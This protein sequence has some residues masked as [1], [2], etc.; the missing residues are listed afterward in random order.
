[1][2][3]QVEMDQG[4]AHVTINRPPVN[5]IS[6]DFIAE[7]RDL[8]ERLSKDDAIRAV[9]FRS[10]IPGRF[11]AGADLSD[12]LTDTQDDEPLADRLRRANK[13][14]RDAFYALEQVPHPT[15]AAIDG[16]CFGGGLEFAL[17]CDYR[18]M[19]DDGKAMVGLTET[20]LGLFPGAGGTIRLPRLVGLGVAKDMIY[21]GR[22]ILAPEAKA[23]GLVTEIYRPDEWQAETLAFAR[24]I[25]GRPTLALR[26]AK[27]A[28]LTG[29]NF[30]YQA[31]RLE[32]DGF[33]KV[34]L[35]ED[36]MEGLQAFWQKRAPEFKGR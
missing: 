30:P 20:N 22:R 11:I 9:L 6:L 14:W 29:L 4:L 1:M 16:H 27:Q 34:A 7:L 12:I 26:L 5:A 21:R 18:L 36:A 13:E 32:E 10:P 28:I 17:C 31:D 3:F 33:V 2:I 19:I 8:C 23:I 25:A 35:S 15:I 24:E